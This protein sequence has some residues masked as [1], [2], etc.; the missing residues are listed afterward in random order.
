VVSD[1]VETGQYNAESPTPA[2][3]SHP[4]NPPSE[5]NRIH[6][7]LNVAESP[8]NVESDVSRVG[9]SSGHGV[10]SDRLIDLHDD[11]A[12][13]LLDAAAVARFTALRLGNGLDHRG[14]AGGGGVH[15]DCRVTVSGM[16]SDEKL[17]TNYLIDG[18]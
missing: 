5:E 8:I 18:S 1:V 14:D 13:G 10:A 12:A 4:F 17:P 11:A 9:G 15:V 6:V 16:R 7:C 2:I 3:P